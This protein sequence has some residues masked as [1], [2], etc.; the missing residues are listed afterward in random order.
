MDSIITAAARALAQGDPLGALKRISLRDDPP[1]LALRGIAMAQLGDFSR[2]KLLLQKAGKAF[3]A[4][5]AMARARCVVAEAEVALASRDLAWP[6]RALD[7]ARVVL[8][9]HHD[10]VNAAYAQQLKIRRLVLIGQLDEAERLF[11]ALPTETSKTPLPFSLRAAHALMAFGIAIRRLQIP[12]ARSLLENAQHAAA[13]ARIPAL[14]A[15]TNNAARIL[16]EPAALV[17]EHG[18]NRPLLLDEVEELFASKAFIV[19]ACRYEVR[20]TKKRVS[21]TRRPILF[22]LLRELANAWPHDASRHSLIERVF[23]TKYGDDS[24]RVRLRVEIGRLRTA[25]KSIAEIN[26]TKDGFELSPLRSKEVVVLA[27][28][29]E[30][31]HIGV[32]ALLADGEC[33]S[34]SAVALALGSSQRSAQRA[35]EALAS[36]GK[37]QMLGQGRARRWITPPLPGFA[38]T[39]LLPPSFPGD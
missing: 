20:S 18:S 35:L 32:L 25:I 9:E 13:A 4:K 19:D 23:R 30:D 38:T 7:A 29:F 28:L 17:T 26:A 27:R 24:H 21:L 34:S 15:E 14:I 36:Q 5:E 37:V 31:D 33:W 2:A 12:K 22:S 8:E 16:S 10:F 3:G 39:L 11:D 1:A 6:S